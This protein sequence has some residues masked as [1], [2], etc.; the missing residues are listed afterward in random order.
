MNVNNN[1]NTHYQINMA[2]S[3]IRHIAEMESARFETREPI[4]IGYSN[5]R[6]RLFEIE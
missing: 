1:N 2:D 4:K 3:T 5:T 6:V